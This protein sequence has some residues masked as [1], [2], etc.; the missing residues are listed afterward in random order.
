MQLWTQGGSKGTCEGDEDGGPESNQDG[1]GHKQG[2]DRDAMAQGVDGLHRGEV[3]FLGI[4]E[5][6]KVSATEHL[7][8]GRLHSLPGEALC[9]TLKLPI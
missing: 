5:M 9:S 3:G 4:V 7:G 6:E 2:H 1:D 8:K